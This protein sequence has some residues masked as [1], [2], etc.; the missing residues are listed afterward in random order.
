VKRHIEGGPP[1]TALDPYAP[2]PPDLA[3]YK[4]ESTMTE[5]AAPGPSSGPEGG[6]REIVIEATAETLEGHRKEG[7]SGGFT[8]Y[9]DES[10]RL[11]GGGTAPAP[12]NYLCMALAF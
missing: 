12:L 1:L 5:R 10:A 6:R 3:R 7:K 4:E 9:S 8:L 2:I 11:G